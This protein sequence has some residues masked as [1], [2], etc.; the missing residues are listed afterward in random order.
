MFLRDPNSSI[1]RQVRTSPLGRVGLPEDVALVAL[2]LASDDAR[3]VTGANI[4]VDGG[5]TIGIAL[6]YGEDVVSPSASVNEE[7]RGALRI[8]DTVEVTTADGVAEAY[9]FTPEGSAQGSWPG[10]LMYTDIMGI[11]PAFLIMAQRVADAGF[12]VLVPN[13]FYRRG[14]PPD[15]PRSVHNPEQLGQLLELASELTHD[16]IGRDAPAFVEALKALPT[17]AGG[18]V[19]C[20]GYCMS[21]RMAVWTAEAAPNDVAL[22]ASIHGTEMATDGA[23]SPAQ[24]AAS[25]P[26]HYYFALADTDP[27]M[28]PEQAALLK[29]ALEAAAANFEIELYPGTFHGFAVLDGSY[30]EAA[31]E[32]H[33][34]RLE[35]HLRK[36]LTTV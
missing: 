19:G 8:T 23:D 2:F 29:D 9:V 12:T 36:A 26:A 27:F 14:A 24:I 3:Y 4:V 1:H 5:Q 10:V 20:I 17:T 32:R 30:D 7:L 16:V 28:R 35:E 22:V 18:P 25:L 11:R 33:Y 34:E 6:S 31:A 21:G 15:P 13:L